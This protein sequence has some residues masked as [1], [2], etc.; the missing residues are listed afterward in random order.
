MEQSWTSGKFNLTEWENGIFQLT[1]HKRVRQERDVAGSL[2][3]IIVFPF[4]ILPELEFIYN[5]PQTITA[6]SS[7]QSKKTKKQTNNNNK[8]CSQ[9]PGK[10]IKQWNLSKVFYRHLAFYFLLSTH[11]LGTLGNYC[12]LSI[13]AWKTT[14]NSRPLCTCL[15]LA[16]LSPPNDCDSWGLKELDMTGWLNWLNS[17]SSPCSLNPCWF[18]QLHCLPPF[19]LPS[20]PYPSTSWKIPGLPCL[21]PEMANLVCPSGR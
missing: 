19:S 2:F 18:L 16:V 4:F 8:Y 14:M 15:S 11:S 10:N 3:F 21:W 9:V 12:V 20:N 17:T 7:S 1:K 5:L 13:F 6:T